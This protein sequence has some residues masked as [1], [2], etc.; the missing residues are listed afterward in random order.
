M[1]KYNSLSMK[2]IL[3]LLAIILCAGILYAQ[4]PDR[5]K[6]PESGAPPSMKLPPI[7]HL[8]L[9]NGLNVVLME[10]HD[11]PL[12]QVELIVR[13]G[14]ALDPENLSGLA[15]MTAAMMEEGAGKMNSLELADAIDFLGATISP[16]A[17]QHSC[18]VSMHT[19]LSKLDAALELF[20]DMA[21]RP[22]FPKEELERNRKDLL[23]TLMQ[24]HDEPRAIASVLYNRT[25]F[26]KE[27]PYGRPSI[28][29]EK[30]IRAMKVDDLKKFHATYFHPGNANLIVVG[31]VTA[32]LIMPKLEAILGK[33]EDRTVD[34]PV[35]QT[36]K[37]VAERT[38]FLVDK[39][40]APQSEI[41]IGR[42]GADRMTEDYYSL[43]VMNTIL[44]GSFTSRLNQNLREKHGYTYGAG[45]S[46]DFRKLPGAFTASSAVQSAIT[47]SAL[48]EFFKELNGILQPIPDEEV[49]RAKNY[50]T[51]RYPERFQSV[52]QITTQLADLV[53]YNLPDDYFNNYGSKI[54]AITTKDVQTVAKKYLDPEKVA[55]IIVGD[56]KTIEKPIAELNLGRIVN[57]TI[58]D[59]LGSIPDLK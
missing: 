2:I 8:K 29:N 10:K 58:E 45:S 43:L 40:G 25:I 14:S 51:L 5:S 38:I 50:L 52:G 28:G 41:R 12:V 53:T 57:L 20:G 24:W 21:L 32:N 35:Y 46:F 11:V 59:V 16:Y 3:S 23:T 17:G 54:N 9:S 7:Q 56:R 30:S 31:D 39:P 13:A 44:G 55:I 22:T 1:N 26:G 18:G 15:S 33:W 4:A 48:I 47:D 19:P 36:A 34:K 49:S 37:Q 27:H 42:I 6:P